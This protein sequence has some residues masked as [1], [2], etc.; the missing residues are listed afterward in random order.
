MINKKTIIPYG[1][2]YIDE[3]DILC[4]NEV[5]NSDWLTS[6]PAGI[7]FETNF[8]H[9]SIPSFFADILGW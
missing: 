4:V 8:A 6:G 3:H 1:R 2:Q 9:S 7:N 5:L